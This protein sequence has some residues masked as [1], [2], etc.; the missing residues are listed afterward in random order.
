MCGAGWPVSVLYGL[1]FG[2]DFG[3]VQMY[4]CEAM[5]IPV[6][7]H[8]R[9]AYCDVLLIGHYVVYT[10]EHQPRSKS[11][12]FIGCFDSHGRTV[13]HGDHVLPK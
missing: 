6:Q 11:S 10:S 4:L 5:T 1:L 2:H 3:S 12:Y 7:R 8:R 9:A 13:G